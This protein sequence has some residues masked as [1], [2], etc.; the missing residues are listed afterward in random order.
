MLCL[1]GVG[2]PQQI[3]GRAGIPEVSTKEKTLHLVVL[4]YGEK[5]RIR[6]SLRSPLA[7]PKVNRPG[8]RDHRQIDR[9]DRSA[10]AAYGMWQKEQAR[11]LL[12]DM[13]WS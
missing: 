11:F 12:G 3:S 2:I 6:V 9:R 4:E 7:G 5:W 13:F 8:I 10:E 1:L